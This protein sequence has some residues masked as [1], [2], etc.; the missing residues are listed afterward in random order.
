MTPRQFDTPYEAMKSAIN[1]YYVS[2]VLPAYL[3]FIFLNTQISSELAVLSISS[4]VF[5][6]ILMVAMIGIVAVSSL[7]PT[8]TPT[9]SFFENKRTAPI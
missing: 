4:F 6:L 8:L 2:F 5:G 7:K 9:M 1:R 3:L